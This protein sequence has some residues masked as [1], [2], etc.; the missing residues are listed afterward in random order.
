MKLIAAPPFDSFPL[1]N[2]DIQD[3]AGIPGPVA[4]LAA[5]V[6]AADGVLFVTPEYNWSMPAR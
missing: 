2:Q 3:A 1:Y 5:A 6:R 4:D